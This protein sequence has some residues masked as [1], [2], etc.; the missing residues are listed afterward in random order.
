MK[1]V[2]QEKEDQYDRTFKANAE[3]PVVISKPTKPMLSPKSFKLSKIASLRESAPS[4]E[5]C[6]QRC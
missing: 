4:A 1:H 2:S 3:I 6:S 5:S